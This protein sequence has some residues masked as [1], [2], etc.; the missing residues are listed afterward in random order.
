MKRPSGRHPLEIK[1]LAKSYDGFQVIQ[2]FTA[3]VVRGEKI[4]L[5]GRNGSGKT[6]LLKSLIRSATGYIDDS[7]RQFPIDSGT[8]SGATRWP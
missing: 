6:T 8:V 7:E 1:S 3:S 5:M 4:A 2:P